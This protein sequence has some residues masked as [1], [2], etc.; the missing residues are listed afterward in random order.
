[1]DYKVQETSPF[2]KESYY[3]PGI[4]VSQKLN[5]WAFDNSLNDISEVF[6]VNNGY[7]VAQISQVISEGVKPLKDVKNQVKQEVLKEKKFELAK[8]KAAEVRS[9]IN[10][11]LTKVSSIDPK[12][13]VSQTGEFTGQGS[14]PNVG[15]DYNFK[16]ESLSLKVGTL[17]EPIKGAR[18]YYLLKVLSRTPFDSS[19][20]AIQRNTI[21]DQLLQQK[22][23]SFF[24]QWLSN[25]KKNADIVDNRRQ[26]FGM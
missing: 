4:G 18:G 3:I 7:V 25:L 26:F 22:K 10:G 8:K 6:S 2:T 1:M 14:I 15:M 13:T 9:K 20:Y 19:A 11:D 5:D 17:S 12:A 23:S 16:E 21:R 24:S